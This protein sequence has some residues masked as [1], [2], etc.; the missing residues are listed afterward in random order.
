M[1]YEF[2]QAIILR[3]IKS[4]LEDQI[5]LKVLKSGQE[6]DSLDLYFQTQYL[7]EQLYAEL[8]GWT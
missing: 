1:N 3:G 6:S 8:K 4:H 5:A 2:V 7:S